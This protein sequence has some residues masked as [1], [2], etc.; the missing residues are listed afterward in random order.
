VSSFDGKNKLRACA[1]F[2]FVADE[3]EWL[4]AGD[5]Y[6]IVRAS[7]PGIESLF[8]FVGCDGSVCVSVIY[9]GYCWLLYAAFDVVRVATL[10]SFSCFPQV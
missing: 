7:I 6:R 4:E 9:A 1:Q 3:H 8:I 2:V 10:S 5:K